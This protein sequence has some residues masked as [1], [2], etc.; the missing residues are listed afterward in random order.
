MNRD[1]TTHRAGFTLIEL[2]IAAFVFTTGL[3]VLM[4]SMSSM[5]NMQKFS[6]QE[7]TASNWANFLLEDLQIHT[8]KPVPSGDANTFLFG[9]APPLDADTYDS[10]NNILYV[11]G[12]N[13]VTIAMEAV[14][15]GVAT[16]IFTGTAPATPPNPIEVQ[17]RFMV[18][19]GGRTITYT[20]SKMIIY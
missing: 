4:G 1:V 20:A 12:L 7:A 11:P 2:M 18:Q 14:V 15:D 9:Y 16:D 5:Y 8:I 10:V 17:V 3:V 19:N 6:D 13:Q